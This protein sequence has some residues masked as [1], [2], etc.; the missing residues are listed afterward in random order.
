MIK[1]KQYIKKK[2]DAIAF[3][4]LEYNWRFCGLFILML[5]AILLTVFNVYGFYVSIILFVLAYITAID[6]K[7]SVAEIKKIMWESKLIK[8]CFKNIIYALNFNAYFGSLLYVWPLLPSI[9][10]AIL[11][12]CYSIEVTIFIKLLWLVLYFF[13]IIHGYAYWEG[14]RIITK[15]SLLR[16]PKEAWPENLHYLIPITNWVKTYNWPKPKNI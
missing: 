1:F 10:Y 4:T 5:R 11:L 8:T 2:V 7:D 3:W 9:I 16:I 12:K 15:N 14:V 6:K 13:F